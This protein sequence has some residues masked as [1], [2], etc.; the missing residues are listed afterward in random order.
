MATNSSTEGGVISS[1]RVSARPWI[2]S[3]DLVRWG[4]I[5]QHAIL[6]TLL[7]S[8]FVPILL[9]VS[10]SLRPSI[11]IY[12]HFWALPWPIYVKNYTSAL[13]LLALPMLHTLFLYA[14]SV[15]GI[16]AGAS[17]AG[18][19]FAQLRF[20]GRSVLFYLVLLVMMIP[21]T[22]VLTPN[23]I[24]ANQLDLRNSLWGMIIF[25][26]FGGHPFAIFLFRSFFQAQPVEMFESARVDGA[27][28]LRALWS[29]AIPLVWPI[30]IT[31]AI[32][33]FLGIYN[34]LIWP[35]LMLTSPGK[36]TLMMALQGYNP[37]GAGG[38]MGG[39]FA[40]L[41][42][43]G[44]IAAGYVFASIPQLIILV[45][46]MRYFIQGLTSGAVKM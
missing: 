17:V 22:I 12:V 46:G 34:D 24:L 2:P 44:G 35:T 16:V 9:M 36:T 20:P 27:S 37:A 38:G 13:A 32:M 14:I 11:D 1:R 43:M 7:F 3:R 26:I 30:I 5:V 19:A 42:N 31:L 23:F 33:Q 40:A 10:M 29:I 15:T 4:A 45:L 41:P 28:E 25:Y 18:Y 21:G 8:L 39:L 6:L